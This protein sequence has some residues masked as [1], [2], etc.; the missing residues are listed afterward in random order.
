MQ[1]YDIEERRKS[2]MN[3]DKRFITL[4]PMKDKQPLTMLGNVDSRLFTGENQL[5][6]VYDD[7]D[8]MWYLRYT[9]GATPHGLQQRFTLFSNLVDFV[10][11]YYKTRNIEIVGVTD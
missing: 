10:R 2:K 1:G 3:S 8:G 9:V 7:R 5:L 6:A 11:E 4:Q